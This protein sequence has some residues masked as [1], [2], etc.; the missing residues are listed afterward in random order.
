MFALCNDCLGGLALYGQKLS[1]KV[2][3][4]I[5]ESCSHCVAA[6]SHALATKVEALKQVCDT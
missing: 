6:F 5:L 1:Y 2:T 4:L 3:S